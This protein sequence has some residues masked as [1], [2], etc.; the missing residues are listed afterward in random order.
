MKSIC[1]ALLIVLL[2]S[3][4]GC[5]KDMGKNPFSNEALSGK[6]IMKKQ[7]LKEYERD[8]LIH[9]E[10]I[11][12]FDNAYMQFNADGTGLYNIGSS[13]VTF[14]WNILNEALTITKKLSDD[15]VLVTPYH[16]ETL[17]SNELIVTYD[18]AYT[19]NNNTYREVSQEFYTR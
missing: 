17:S 7:I 5:K 12:S 11:T 15:Q 19:I 14:K 13:N 9:D 18:Y 16:V 3:S 4:F 6:W 10:T 2:I 8:E 1:Y